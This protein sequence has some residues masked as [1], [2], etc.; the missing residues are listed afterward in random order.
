V[1]TTKGTVFIVDDNPAIAD[2]LQTLLESAGLHVEVYRSSSE[3]VAAYDPFKSGCLVLDIE[4]EPTRIVATLDCL[5]DIGFNL[6]IVVISWSLDET[7]KDRAKRAGVTAFLEK[8]LSETQLLD[9]IGRAI[10]KG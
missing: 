9:A 8:P 4:P 3:L 5:S 1:M 10:A 2:S 6:A 7:V